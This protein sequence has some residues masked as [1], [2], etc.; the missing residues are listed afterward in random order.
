M[1]LDPALAGL[2]DTMA[3]SASYVRPARHRPRQPPP[4]P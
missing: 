4:S 1:P 3:A 2:L